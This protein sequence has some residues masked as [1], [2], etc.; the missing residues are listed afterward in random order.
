MEQLARAMAEDEVEDEK[1][2]QDIAYSWA[3]I[4]KAEVDDELSCG[5]PSSS[6]VPEGSASAAPSGAAV[7]DPGEWTPR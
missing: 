7:A 6:W 2:K 3:E 1:R 4:A 5:G